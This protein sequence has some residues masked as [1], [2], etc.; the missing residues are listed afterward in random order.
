MIENL[1]LVFSNNIKLTSLIWFGS[2]HDYIYIFL[3]LLWA[4]TKHTSKAYIF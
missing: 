3:I 4:N 1:K 2:D